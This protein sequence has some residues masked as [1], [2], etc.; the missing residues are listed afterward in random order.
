M[1]TLENG[2]VIKSIHGNLARNSIWYSVYGS[3]GHLESAREDAENGGVSRLYRS[4]DSFEGE[5][6]TRL[7]SYEPKDSQS[8]EAKSYGHGSSDYYT[9]NTA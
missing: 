2:A 4:L 6:A 3:K 8:E 1:I 5:N 9:C 7:E